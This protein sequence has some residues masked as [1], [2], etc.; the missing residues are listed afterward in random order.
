MQVVKGYAEGLSAYAEAHKEEVLLDELF[1]ISP[2]QMIAYSQL[3]LFVSN[4]ADRLVSQILKKRTPRELPI[5]TESN[6][7]N[8]VALSSKKPDKTLVFLP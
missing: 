1:P 7:S 6:G 3:Q 2:I 5:Q 8:L 4:A